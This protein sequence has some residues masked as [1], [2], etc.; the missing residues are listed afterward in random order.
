MR[1]LHADSAKA[2]DA[3]AAGSICDSETGDGGCDGHGD[4]LRPGGRTAEDDAGVPVAPGNQASYDNVLKSLFERALGVY[5]PIRFQ[6]TGPIVV[7]ASV[8]NVN[9]CGT[10]GV[11]GQWLPGIDAS[12]ALR[13]GVLAQLALSTSSGSGYTGRTSSS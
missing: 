9:A 3:E 11:S 4:V 8:N 5:G 10:G 6:A 13:S 12:Q 1:T 7:S 2:N